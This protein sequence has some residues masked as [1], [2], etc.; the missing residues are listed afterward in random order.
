MLENSSILANSLLSGLFGLD[1]GARGA[2][3]LHGEQVEGHR[4][5]TG[6]RVVVECSKTERFP[7]SMGAHQ[8]ESILFGA[9]N[10]MSWLLLPLST[11]G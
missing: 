2:A 8:R 4:W 3:R 11:W 7:I 5:Q 9:D 6:V 10:E 1:Q